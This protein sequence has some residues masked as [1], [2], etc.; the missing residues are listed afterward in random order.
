MR[1]SHRIADRRPIAAI[2]AAGMMWAGGIARITAP[3]PSA[4]AGVTN[5]RLPAPGP[6]VT[7]A[8]LT[9][10]DTPASQPPA[11]GPE[12]VVIADAG[13]DGP[14]PKAVVPPGWRPAPAITTTMKR[15]FLL[16]AGT[17]LAGT[18]LAGCGPGG[19]AAGSRT[20]SPGG[21]TAGSATPAQ[22]PATSRTPAVVPA[23]A[24]AP[25]AAAATCTTSD[26]RVSLDGSATDSASHA[27]GVILTLTNSSR[28]TCA[29]DG[30]PGL[31]LLNSRHQVLQT[32]T[33]R[34]S[35][36]Y[37]NDPGRRLLDLAPGRTARASLAW[38]H[39]RS[40][41]VSASYLNITPPESTAHLTISFRQHIDGGDL[42][43]TA[44]AR[45]V[46]F[47]I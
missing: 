29:L 15:C 37:A 6:E 19:T 45:T 23:S 44:V 36:F 34:G 24:S 40:S 25:S 26:L 8:T 39:A 43:V 32:I 14:G 3:A 4:P 22:T 5:S 41:A 1:C 31:E 7:R 30:Y 35:T 18:V 46:S 47:R 17:V 38:T 28:H 10:T 16:A 21:R 2:S 13:G 20:A 9:P 12:T 27:A 42:D 33:H 11:P